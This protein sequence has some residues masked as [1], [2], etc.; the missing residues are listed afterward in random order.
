MRIGIDARCLTGAFTGDRTY[1][2]GLIGGLSRI[3]AD[4]ELVLFSSTAIPA[5]VVPDSPKIKHVVIPS[6]WGRYFSF[7]QL[8]QAASQHHCDVV[9]VQYSVSPLFKQPVVT[10]IH[11][12]SFT[13]FPECFKLKDRL[14]LSRSVP[15]AMK[16]ASQV[17]TVS[18]SSRNDI[19]KHY[20]VNPDILHATPLAVPMR[21]C[22][23]PKITWEALSEHYK[24]S[25][26]Y[27]ML[28]GVRQ[29]RKN[30]PFAIQA[31]AA[32]RRLGGN[33]EL[34]VVGKPGWG[35]DELSATIKQCSLSD[36]VRYTGY[37]PDEHLS[38]LY[39]HAAALLYPSLYEGFGL[40]PL[41]AMSLG[42]IVIASDISVMHEVCGEAAYLI[43]TTESAEWAKRMLNI[44]TNTMTA[45][46]QRGY[47]QAQR[48]SWDH[49]ALQTYAI[50]KLALE[51]R[52]SA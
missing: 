37:V 49:T 7:R 25:A 27:F 14:I 18:E 30:L 44:S 20:E 38:A 8:P 50:Y 34:L 41:E 29:P 48:F 26:P 16:S 11:D 31:F 19:L 13:L 6:K 39:T 23:E 46:K 17:I 2:E 45:M 10:T 12:I 15:A 36:S 28:L 51:H 21:L 22:K 33:A 32:Y 3:N 40:P 1:W 24:I 42:C 9:H 52:K 35:D 43:K 5:G 47:Q 4:I